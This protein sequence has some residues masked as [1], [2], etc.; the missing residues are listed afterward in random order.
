MTALTKK[1]TALFAASLSTLVLAFEPLD[2]VI[3]IVD[4]DVITQSDFDVRM[5]QVEIN[6][7]SQANKPSEDEIKKQVL[8]RLIIE[9]LQ[10]QLAKRA[11]V[12]ISNER[13]TEAM[14]G[15]A[16]RNKMTL[17]QFKAEIES[18]GSSYE[19]MRE[20]IRTDMIIQNVQQGHLRGEI[21]ISEEEIENFLNSADGKAVTLQQYN[22]SHIL[23]PL[24]GSDK[25]L[26]KQAKKDLT[27]LKKQLEQSPKQF[28]AYTQ[29][30]IYKQ[31][32]ISG[33]NL[34]WQKKDDL[35]SL[36]T[37]LAD[38]LDKGEIS[39][40]IR[41]GAGWHLVKMNDKV[42]GSQV[43]AQTHARHILISPSEVRSME[44]A[45]DLANKLYERLQENEDFT[46]L[47]KEYSDDPGSALQGGDLG[48]SGPG[49]FVPA[50]DA[51]LA[52]LKIDGI[53]QPFSTEYGW[54]ICQKLGERNHDV[55]KEQWNNKAYQAL[56]ERKFREELDNWL[57]TI[58]N[59]AFIEIKE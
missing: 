24:D 44:Q 23:L 31:Y 1:F 57:A 38:S 21:Q 55:T 40:P 22:I 30:K 54:H 2:K 5:K 18:Q 20:Q 43:E 36:F 26:E 58:R 56:Y 42:G 33:D 46:L 39:E 19:I 41:S 53:S 3:V 17:K 13:L 48:W 25:A 45:K 59:E 16:K 8:D 6:L 28:K 34:N 37:N 9:N 4:D 29:G 47:A 10:I 11:G 49:K 51:A 15:I 35:P 7:A 52:E 14:N 12:K 50:F 27:A 32:A